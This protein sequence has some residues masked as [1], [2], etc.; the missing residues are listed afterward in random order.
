MEEYKWVVYSVLCFAL[1]V[2]GLIIG[3]SLS[4]D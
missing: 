4:E 1:F 2:I 3:K